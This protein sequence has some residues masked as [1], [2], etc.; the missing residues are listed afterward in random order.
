MSLQT[1]AE[2]ILSLQLPHPVRVG[3]DGVTAS[4]KTTLADDL[5]QVIHDAGRPVIRVSVDDF[6]R[7]STERYARGRL[8]PDGY[9]LDAF[10]YQKLRERLLLSPGPGGN[11]RYV[12]AVHDQASDSPIGTPEERT[13]PTHSVV[14]IDGVFLFRPEINYL[15]DYRIFLDVDLAIAYERGV[16][17]DHEW[18]GSR[19]KAQERYESRYIPAERLYLEQVHP[20]KLADVVISNTHPQDRVFRFALRR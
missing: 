15:W 20:E 14:L 2:A 18:I 12:T 17:R 8:S 6:H 10:D 3:I 13:A 11:R 4:G 19:A 16:S 5:A 7:P 9:Y 1:V